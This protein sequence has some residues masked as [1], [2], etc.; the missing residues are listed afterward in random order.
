MAQF[1]VTGGAGFIGSHLAEELARRGHRVRV[2]DALTTGKRSNLDHVPGVE[3]LEGDLA[4]LAF[5]ARAV[6]GVEFVLHQAAIPSVPKSV[7]DPLTS[8]RSNVDGTLNLLL[9]ARD[10]NVRRVVF[11]ASSSAYGDTAT[12]PK[13][14]N[15]PSDPLSP[16]A[17]QKVVGEMYLRMFTKL[18]GLETVS[19]RYFNVFGP[20]QDPSS[21]YSGVISVFATALLDGR[22]PTI[23]G[24]G[25]QT[26]D[27]TYVADVVNGVLKACEAPAASGEVINVAT[28]GRISLNRLFDTMKAIVQS[29]VTPVYAEA[30]AGDVRDSQAD[31]SKARRLLGF[32]PTVSLEDGLRRTVEWYRTTRT[33]TPA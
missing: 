16:Y 28:G 11:A 14:E 13:H 24:D 4:D 33:E 29:Q 3:F 21:A 12:L 5:A 31:I 2:A 18:Y 10:A 17:L 19:I 23:Y 8:H 25:E 20:R 26:R 1:L 30:R 6:Q 15:M 9:A 27:F 32:E 22:A 7:A